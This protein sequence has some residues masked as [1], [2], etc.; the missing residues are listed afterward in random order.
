MRW[1]LTQNKRTET[2]IE[3]ASASTGLL[4]V[5]RW[6]RQSDQDLLEYQKDC[7]ER[8]ARRRGERGEIGFDP[9]YGYFYY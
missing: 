5:L 1:F 3:V 8:E 7:R 2:L 6:H 4:D 9:E